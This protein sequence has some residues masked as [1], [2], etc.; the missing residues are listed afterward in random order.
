[1]VSQ[2]SQSQNEASGIQKSNA[3][4]TR[5][6]LVFYVVSPPG[7]VGIDDGYIIH[8]NLDSK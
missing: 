3:E 7:E 6:V 4:A 5:S 8:G 1:M 2:L